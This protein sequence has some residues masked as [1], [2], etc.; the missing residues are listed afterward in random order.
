LI[1]AD[2]SAAS[3]TGNAFFE[4]GKKTGPDQI[5]FADEFF[6]GR[7]VQSGRRSRG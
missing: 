3:S 4:P 1:I 2:R 5:L 7:G 6:D